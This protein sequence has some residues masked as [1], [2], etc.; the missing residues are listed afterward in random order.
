[1]LDDESATRWFL[2][3]LLAL[4]LLYAPLILADYAWDDEALILARQA[5]IL[6]GGETT[7]QS[8]KALWM[9]AGDEAQAS[10]Y[11]RPAFLWSLDLDHSL[12]PGN[13][14]AAHIHSLLWHLAA[15]LALFVLL[16]Q[17]FSGP[18]ALIGTALFAFHPVQSEAVAWLAARNDLMAGALGFAAVA[19][20]LPK[21]VGPFRLL[22]G[23][24]CLFGAL[25]SKEHAVAF[26][27][28]LLVLQQAREKSPLA[29]SRVL[30]V[31]AAVL[32]YLVMRLSSSLEAP[33]FG[34]PPWED[35]AKVLIHYLALVAVPHPLSVARTLAELSWTPGA[36]AA[37][38]VACLGLG[39]TLRRG[40]RLAL[41]GLGFAA[42]AFAPVVFSISA[43]G[44]LGDRFLYL[45]LGGL[46]I[47][48]AAALPTGLSRRRTGLL[49]GTLSLCGFLLVSGR[50]PDWR[51]SERLWLA[52]VD[53]VNTTYAHAN[54][55]NV[56]HR[57]G[58]GEEALP[59][60][61]RSLEGPA[62]RLDRCGDAIRSALDLEAAPVALDLVERAYEA[63]CPKTP[64]RE[65]VRALL[66]IGLGR[67]EEA[68]EV[69]LENPDDPAGRV[70]LVIALRA[71]R[72]GET[73]QLAE[74]AES[75]RVRGVPRSEFDRMLA[76]LQRL[77]PLREGGPE[78]PPPE[79]SA[80]PTSPNQTSE[81]D[82]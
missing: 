77:S 64:R 70:Q 51:D 80:L 65:G 11:Y 39:V 52:E 66:L 12:W 23:G 29:R 26:P 75:Y 71:Q 32:G 40:G 37:S 48:L 76:A 36:V 61:L 4:A 35:G 8:R 79:E 18:A 2:F 62:P 28:L 43:I 56:M 47:S 7:S 22:L 78:G 69:A 42:L 31:G 24:L 58:R 50:L 21:R 67:V 44:Q 16:R 6:E 19:A 41:L 14:G 49:L 17:L 68:E 20:L 59:H 9:T 46:A 63:G 55:A 72:L 53:R 33:A 3:V 25:L 74:I 34:L 15:V 27:I 45:P 30:V 81:K 73:Q 38:G 57:Q 13:A 1:M 10:G 82:P 54:L 5:A 60:Y